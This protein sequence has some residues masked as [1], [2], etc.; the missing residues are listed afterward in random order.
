MLL[1]GMFYFPI[2]NDDKTITVKTMGKEQKVIGVCQAG[3]E[4]MS[5]LSE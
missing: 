1:F 4:W 3:A 2:M 5:E